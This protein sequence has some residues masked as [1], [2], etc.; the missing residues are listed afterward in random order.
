MADHLSTWHDFDAANRDTYPQVLDS[1]V[2]L[3]FV[4]GFIVDPRLLSNFSPI[5]RLSKSAGG[6]LAL[7]QGAG[8]MKLCERSAHSENE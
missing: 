2:Q 3:C 8:A 4:S 1:P 5:Q 7:Y 6:R